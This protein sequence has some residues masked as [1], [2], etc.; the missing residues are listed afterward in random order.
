MGKR[1]YKIGI[2]VGGTNTDGVLVDIF[3]KIIAKTKQQTTK[4]LISGIDHTIGFLLNQSK[5][6]P[7]EIK[8]V[9]LGTTHCTNAI[10]ERKNLNKIGIIRLCKP[11]SIAIPPLTDFPEDLIAYFG[12]H[13]H[14][15][16]GGYEFDG[17]LISPLDE[18]EVRSV[19]RDMK[20]QVDSLAVSGVFSKTN[21]EQELQVKKWAN[22]ELGDISVSL[23]HTIGGLGLL[24][25]EN[26]T[27]INACLQDIAKHMANSFENAVSKYGIKARLFFGQNDGT[28][29]SVDAARDFPVLTIACGPTNS[30]RGGGALSGISKG[31][32]IDV[33]GTTTDAGILVDGFPRE[34]SRANE[35]GGVKTNFRMPDVLSIGLGGG[36]I[37]HLDQDKVTAGPK[38]VGFRLK[39]EALAF[40]GKT[41]TMTDYALINETLVIEE[42]RT[43]LDIQNDI[44]K[45]SERPI[46][47]INRDISK[48]VEN[49]VILLLEK[50]KN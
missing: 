22:E 24:E 46:D 3:G 21:P 43:K 13:V 16:N 8:F 7:K 1:M 40:G 38:S 47:D 12:S 28:L 4:D 36:S 39:Q 27:I 25:R 35:I 37:I 26:A 19:L 6:D 33:G 15:V 17:R 31:I 10:V 49:E 23:S 11:A 41:M 30:I 2:D 50:L 5:V 18:K 34:S 20:G 32:V 29:M 44:K 48:F 14:M 45:R 9:M 42:A